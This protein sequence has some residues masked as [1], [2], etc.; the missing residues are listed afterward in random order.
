MK[1]CRGSGPDIKKSFL[2][3][4]K[5]GFF[6]VPLRLF[7]EFPAAHRAG[8][9][10]PPPLFRNAEPARTVRA[11]VITVNPVILNISPLAVK[12]A[13][14]TVPVFQKE[15]IFFI[16][17]RN[18]AGKNSE[19][20]PSQ[21]KIGQKQK[22]EKSRPPRDSR[23]QHIKNKDADHQLIPAVASSHRSSDPFQHANLLFSVRSH[24]IFLINYNKWVR[25]LCQDDLRS[26][27]ILV[28]FWR[29]CFHLIYN[30]HVLPP[31][32]AHFQAY[33]I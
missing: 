33:G 19:Q 25:I 27:Y 7:D 14:K 1:S 24:F 13:E 4:W 15:L 26:V 22:R 23:Q 18:V 3:L 29:N 11:L 31:P 12:P 10:D 2:P 9:F 16:P 28:L 17:L 8:N 21:Q 6:Y 30:F 32:A 20:T 5:K